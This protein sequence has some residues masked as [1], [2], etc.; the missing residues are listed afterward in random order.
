MTSNAGKYRIG[1]GLVLSD[2]REDRAELNRAEFQED[3]CDAHYEGE[4]ADAVDD[5]RL[6]RRGVGG[7]PVVPVADQ[8]VGAEAYAFPPEEQLQQVVG[9]HQHQHG[10]GEQREV[11]EEAISRV[12]VVRQVADRIDVDQH[13]DERHHC[14]HH[15]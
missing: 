9:G 4:I 5:E 13:G 1:V 11:G 10:E 2:S 3:Q 14:D 12:G 7:R 15:G 8:Q 6:D